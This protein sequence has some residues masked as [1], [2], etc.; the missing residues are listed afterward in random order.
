M[1]GAA[2]AMGIGNQATHAQTVSGPTFDCARAQ[3]PLSHVI[4]REP[5]TWDADWAL[6]SSY[7]AAYF[8]VEGPNR[9][10]L[11]DGHVSWMR[12]VEVEC[13][14]ASGSV[15]PR[16]GAC[17]TQKYQAR[18]ASYRSSLTGDALAEASLRPEALMALQSR[19]IELG[20]M[21]GSPDGVFGAGT[22]QAIRA[23]RQTLGQPP[24]DF[25]D[26]QQR[27]A[28]LR[29]RPV[30]EA[31]RPVQTPPSGGPA[32]GPNPFASGDPREVLPGM[33]M[34]MLNGVTRGQPMPMPMPIPS[35]S[36]R[37]PPA[38]VS[39]EPDLDQFEAPARAAPTPYAPQRPGAS[40]Q[41]R[42]PESEFSD[43]ETAVVTS[44]L[45]SRAQSA[46]SGVRTVEVKGT[47]DSADA[48]RKDAARLAI[49]QVVGI[50]VDNR[51]RI[52]L[53]VSDAKVS[54]VVNEKLIS[55]TNA[56][57]S[58][59][60]VVRTEQKDGVFEVAA[61]VSVS[62]APL[63]KVLQENAVPTVR[64]DTAT[65]ASTVETLSQEKA[66]AIELYADLIDRADALM[67]IGVGTPQVDPKLP[68]SPDEA[69][70]RIPLTYNVN[71]EAAREWRTKFDLFA[72]K[73]ASV[74]IRVAT[75]RPN[76]D[77]CGFPVLNIERSVR[78]MSSNRANFLSERPS[79]QQHGVA[80]CFPSYET[81][82]G[83][84][85]E[86]L[87]RTFV[88]DSSPYGEVCQPGRPCLHFAEKAKKLRLVVELV[89]ADNTVVYASRMPFRN[90]P[91]LALTSSQREP[92]RD[93]RTFFNYC[94]ASQSPFF[95]TGT[96]NTGVG[97]GDVMVF[98]PKGSK[99]RGYLNLRLSNSVIS[100]ISSVRARI[101]KDTP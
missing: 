45:G 10:Q 30:A 63:L 47:G 40:S 78:D 80:A 100:R 91:V 25:L 75:E 20:F 93:E 23:Y 54:E 56:Y 59:M 2:V 27:T 41:A 46:D 67:K 39:P 28:L 19:L 42:A 55:Y 14:L 72:Q 62:V 74:L 79:G 90:Y 83:V 52:E 43:S 60:D 9:T 84:M 5:S 81:P 4:C 26:Q 35:P 34:G 16:A 1:V 33:I 24:A 97:F 101:D 29:Q 96:R 11:R 94:A 31:R 73:R 50:F 70:L 64:F 36:G 92:Q 95:D 6:S 3:S 87:G 71:D 13:G 53:N 18:A 58:R 32:F 88:D 8:S 21:A 61:R 69:W 68:S 98:P 49:Q 17:V 51:R 38:G 99:I 86:C 65:A 76:T 37:R 15:T 7:W 66:G 77:E 12:S 89:G 85:A 57:V 44:P 48:A 82:D 22:R